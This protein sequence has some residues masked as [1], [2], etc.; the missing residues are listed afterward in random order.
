MWTPDIRT[1]FLI[2]FLVNA[3]LTLMLF[4]FW[5]TQK[6]YY[7]FATW[8]QSLLVISIGYFLFM[9]RDTIPAFFSVIVGSILVVLS[10]IMRLESIGRFFWL[11]PVP[12]LVYSIFIPF[13]GLYL[14]FTYLS[15]STLFRTLISTLIIVPC[16]IITSV[17]AIRV[18]EPESRPLR[19]GFAATLLIVAVLMTTRII[20]WLMTPGDHSL[21]SP[22][23]E[24]TVFFI[25]TIVTD[26]LS[27]GFFLMLNMARSQTELQSSEEEHRMLLLGL[28]DFVVVYAKEMILYANPPLL[29]RF[30]ISDEE[31]YRHSLFDY[32]A[33]ESRAVVAENIRKRDAGEVVPPYEMDIITPQGERMTL[34]LQPSWRT[35]T[36]KGVRATIVVLTDITDR[37]RAEKEVKE[38]GLFLQRLIDT[39]TNPI[40]YKN[41][42]GAYT[43]CNTAFEHYLG[44]QKDQIIGKSVYDLAP[45]K[46]ADIYHAKDRE[47]I[48]HP[49]TQTYESQVRYADGSIH[50]VIFNKATYYD[51]DGNI[52]GIVGIIQDISERKQAEEAVRV[53]AREWEDTFNATSDGICLIDANQTI[54]RCNIRM[55]EILGGIK[56]E[57]LVDKPCWAIV[58]KTTGP[59]PECPFV[60][61]QKTHTRT[62]EEIPVG[63]L[64]FEVTADP[65]LDSSGKFAG[66][67]H[68]MR[69]ITGRKQIERA[70]RESEEKYRTLFTNMTEGFAYCRMMY[71]SE[72]LPEDFIYLNVNPAFDRIIGVKTVTMKRVTEVFPGIRDAFPELFEI[73]G[74]VALTGIPESFEIDFKPSEKLLH[75]SVYSP[76]KEHFVAVFEDITERKRADEALRQANKQ[77]NLLSSITRHDI[78]NQLMALKGYLYLSEEMTD[79]P[80]T[81]LE[82]IK[83]EKQAA[84]TIERQISFTRDYQELGIAVPGWQNVNASIKK[85]LSGL[86]VR[87][88]RIEIDPKNPEV[89]ADRLFEK[90]FYNL[91]DNALRYGGPDMKTIH[92]SSQEFDSGL[93]IVCEDDGEGISA[94]DKKKL[95]TKG[96]GKNTGLGLF[97]SREI[98]AITGITIAENGI[99]GKGA[100]FEIT[101]PKG[102]WRIKEANA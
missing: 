3:F 88:V 5:K 53:I 35:I 57:D 68:I 87:D 56:E 52:D 77:L 81:L 34:Y 30:G 99:P 9:L 66:A 2:L 18:K 8:M 39:I 98:L 44:L 58:H 42:S 97:L 94:E 32:I 16:L 38:H 15:D 49:G 60:S 25:V 1:L 6:T 51:A 37:K 22:D 29:N 71:D 21:L 27:T 24:N 70:L 47:L 95:F 72:G 67:V 78:L 23:P 75:I 12:F 59:I 17:L 46:F 62:Q 63:N 83:K 61:A 76:A 93:H 10:V 89:F 64:W 13:I 14:Y 28:P 33:P 100:R 31:L 20:S 43:G 86:P 73:Y 96:F 74:R 91:I 90:V 50:E 69:D 65:I 36:Y 7:G 102:M 92:I 85:A 55:R 54:Q 26:I 82:Y 101:V 80:K 41:T 40:F 79:N 48:D 45:K 11:K 4:S 19:L 84:D